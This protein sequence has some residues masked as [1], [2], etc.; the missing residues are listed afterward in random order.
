MGLTIVVLVAIAGFLLIRGSRERH[1]DEAGVARGILRTARGRG[2]RPRYLV[3]LVDHGAGGNADTRYTWTIWDADSALRDRA[4]PRDDADPDGS[5]GLVDPYTVGSSADPGQ[6]VLDA[7]AW[8][9]RAGS[10]EFA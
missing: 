5:A 10:S 7:S 2:D 4:Y 8:V 1:Y 6:A 3:E 9:E